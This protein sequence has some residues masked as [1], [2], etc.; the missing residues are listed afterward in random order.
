MSLNSFIFGGD[1]G[2]TPESLRRNRA[3]AEAILAGA[4]RSST[5]RNVGEGL[6]AVAKALQ[7]RLAQNK[8]AEGE[9]LQAEKQK[10]IWGQLSAGAGS[11]F[12]AGAGYGGATGAIADASPT[13]S[14]Q[15]MA[16]LK[17][18]EREDYV[19]NYYLG[20]GLAPHQAAGFTGNLIQESSLNTG[21]RNAGDGQ[22][23]S[24]SIGI[25]QA[26][27]DR[28]RNLMAFAK[29]TGRDV[30]DINAQLDFTLHEMGLGDPEWRSLPGWGSEARA[31]EQLKNARDIQ[32]AAAAGISYER[33][34]GWSAANPTGGHGW[35]NRFGHAQRLAGMGFGQ[36]QDAAP[37]PAPQR[38]PVQ[39]ASLDPSAGM[40]EAIDPRNLAVGQGMAAAGMSPVASALNSGRAPTKTAGLSPVAAA[41]NPSLQPL[42]APREVGA[43][44][45]PPQDNWAGLRDVGGQAPPL[46]TEPPAPAPVQM[47]QAGGAD[48]RLL[49]SIISNPWASDEQRQLATMMLQQTQRQSQ[50]SQARAYDRADTLDQRAY[51]DRVRQEGYARQDAALKQWQRL[52]DDTLFNPM[53]G[54]THQIPVA[55]GAAPSDLGLNPQ[56]GIDEKGNPVLIQLGKDGKAYRTAMPEGVT[57]SKEP[58]K[59]DAGTHYVLY[60]PITRQPVGQVPKDNRG[61]AA[62]TELGKAEGK[63]K[64]DAVASLGTVR[65]VA[66]QIDAQ[67]QSVLDDP[68]LDSSVGS[69]QGRLP[70]FR[71]GAVD[72]D[73]KLERLQGQTFLQARE[74]LRGQGSITDFESQRAEAAMAQLS[75][76]QSEQQ[77]RAALAEFRDAVRSGVAKVEMMAGQGAQGAAP[78]QASAPAA[79]APAAGNYRWNP[80]TGKMEPM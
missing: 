58:I 64:G 10:D 52:D 78:A 75:T 24:D 41:L 8:V 34:A 68:N 26:N 12:G 47:A 49:M 2:Q 77:F 29:G 31:G 42:P 66:S 63:S 28:A 20:K 62:D 72:F 38:G 51:Q 1:T 22:D 57:L 79:T 46:A 54:E 21:A 36:Q 56:Y 18:A 39:V 37:A 15:A 27:G 33:P 16:N 71:Q 5:P 48:P 45:V 9:A 17:P 13:P 76:A 53:T 80:A 74:F 73:K 60:D 30:G 4:A 65:Q 61:A 7:Y 23:G 6:G 43:N 14:G 3:V 55:P 44:P 69:F 40:A 11:S 70:S 50:L 19:M 32:S 59:I 25:M 67:I 35:D